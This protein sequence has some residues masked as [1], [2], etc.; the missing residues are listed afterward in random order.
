M[1]AHGDLEDVRTPDEPDLE[2]FFQPL[3]R[4]FLRRTEARPETSGFRNAS[5]R[6]SRLLRYASWFCL[7]AAESALFSA[8]L[9]IR[10]GW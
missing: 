4:V 5:S 8:V 1:A 6:T 7:N 2:L 9:K 10:I 3:G